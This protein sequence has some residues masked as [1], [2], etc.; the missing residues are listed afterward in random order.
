MVTMVLK[1]LL[2]ET[3]GGR[4]AFVEAAAGGAEEGA[5]RGEV[6]QGK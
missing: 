1:G 2:V 3:L 6:L 4:A 5:G